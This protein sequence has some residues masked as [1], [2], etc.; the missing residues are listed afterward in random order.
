MKPE[1]FTTFKTISS[2]IQSPSYTQAA[3]VLSHTNLEKNRYDS[4]IYLFDGVT[5]KM[6]THTGKETQ[7]RWFNETTLVFS[8]KREDDVDAMSTDLYA[9]PIDGGEAVLKF[10]VPLILSSYQF[11][12]NGDLIGIAVYDVNHPN[13]HTYSKAKRDK[14]ASQL[15]E[16]AYVLN[17]DELPFY[18]NGDAF[19]QNRRLRLIH[20]DAKTQVIQALT[21]MSL[22]VQQVELKRD[23]KTLVF[24]ASRF[25]PIHPLTNELYS[26]HLDT[27]R[28]SKLSQAR[29]QI[30]RFEVFD[31]QVIAFIND[32]K[33]FG[34]NQNDVMAKLE[35]DGRFTQL[36]DPI[37]SVGNSINS[38]ARLY[39][40]KAMGV[41]RDQL[42]VLLTVNDHS[43]LVFFNLNLEKVNEV[44][45]NG[46]CDGVCRIHDQYYMSAMIEQSLQEITDLQ[47]KALTQYNT[48]VFHDLYVAKPQRITSQ[49]DGRPCQGWVLLPPKFNPSAQYPAILVIHGGPKTVYGE[50]Y[51]HEMQVWVNAG[52]VVMYC[53]PIGSDGLDNQFADIRGAYGSNDYDDLMGFVDAV[54]DAYP[55]IDQSRLGVIGGS[56][57]GYMTNWIVSH[58]QRFKAAV[59]QRSI[60]NWTS[61]YG[62]SDIGYFF[63]QDQVQADLNKP[64][65]FNK[66]WDNSPLKFVANVK[67][68]TLIIHSK[69]DYRCPIDQAYQW[70]ASLKLQKVDTK[71]ILFHEEN[72]DLT[73]SGKP[74]ARLSSH[75]HILDWFNQHLS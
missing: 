68:P 50:V 65:D 75:Q 38:D 9:L 61:F 46:S 45:V 5:H 53:N 4:D 3:Y 13:Y 17:I 7:V 11:L 63:V 33:H 42:L 62:V 52:Y 27:K 74:K 60:S 55:A 51:T 67:T 15:K 56:Y 69:L 16:D 66:L 30:S 28:L 22:N 71:L 31:D 20:M 59:T 43:R 47:G 12:E 10:R 70:Y 35:A 64:Q 2:L 39:G 58:T 72:H 6:M 26:Y 57:G 18:A 21:P 8:S 49:R 25:K 44:D 32:R 24:R 73:R 48:K 34:L 23:Q 41:Y 54:C 40:S 19:T 36:Y 37:Y 29:V 14:L 1:T